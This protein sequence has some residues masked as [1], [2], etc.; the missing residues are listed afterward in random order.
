[1][2]KLRSTIPRQKR[3]ASGACVHS[4]NPKMRTSEPNAPT[5][6][7]IKYSWQKFPLLADWSIVPYLKWL[8]A[9]L[10][11]AHNAQQ[12]SVLGI[13]EARTLRFCRSTT[14]RIK[15]FRGYPPR[16]QVCLRARRTRRADWLP[17]SLQVRSSGRGT[18][19]GIK[20][21]RAVG[22]WRSH[23]QCFWPPAPVLYENKSPPID[24]GETNI[25]PVVRTRYRLKELKE[26]ETKNPGALRWKL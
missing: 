22:H 24:Y 8:H 26:Y 19:N 7:V 20:A 21:A 9:V 17:K 13:V 6:A 18:E 3:Q 15:M 25:Q 12:E 2:S 4:Q 5:W 14:G 10:A 1:M 11:F 23:S 16:N